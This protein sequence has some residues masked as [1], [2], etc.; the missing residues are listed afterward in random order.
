M[1]ASCSSNYR[2]APGN[3]G[4]VA[5]AVTADRSAATICGCGGTWK[6]YAPGVVVRIG[7]YCPN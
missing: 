6:L 3:L 2:P 1:G 5:V 4:S 7:R